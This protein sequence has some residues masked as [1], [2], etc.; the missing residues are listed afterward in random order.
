MSAKENAPAATGA[1]SDQRAG[2]SSV[3]VAAGAGYWLQPAEETR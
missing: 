2:G 1:Q 3:T